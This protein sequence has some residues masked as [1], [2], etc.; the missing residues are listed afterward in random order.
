MNIPL[1]IGSVVMLLIGAIA[2]SQR[3]NLWAAHVRRSQALGK[4]PGDEIT[5]KRNSLRGGLFLVLLGGLGIVAMVG[6]MLTPLP[7]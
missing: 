2:I 7:A 3:D 5:W 6:A 4:N 1:V